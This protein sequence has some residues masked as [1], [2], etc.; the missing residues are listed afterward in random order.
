MGLYL[1]RRGWTS[2]SFGSPSEPEPEPVYDPADPSFTWTRIQTFDGIGVSVAGAFHNRTLRSLVTPAWSNTPTGKWFRVNMRLGGSGII[3]VAE[4]YGSTVPSAQTNRVIGSDIIPITVNGERQFT[5]TADT[6]SDPFYLPNFGESG[7]ERI[8]YS[9]YFVGNTVLRWTNPTTGNVTTEWVAG[10]SAAKT[11]SYSGT[12]TNNN[13]LVWITDTAPG[14][15]ELLPIPRNLT[16]VRRHIVMN[17]S[18]DYAELS[19]VRRHTVMG[20]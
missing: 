8:V 16:K 6:W 18:V 5:L 7:H 9:A 3:Q 17:D 10:N 1:G 13:P 11:G 20:D 2:F 14:G 15:P 12:V 19:V 4:L